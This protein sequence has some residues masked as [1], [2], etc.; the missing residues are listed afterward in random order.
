MCRTADPTISRNFR[1]F[2][3]PW[4]AGFCSFFLLLLLLVLFLYIV[5]DL[6]HCLF[7]RRIDE[8]LNVVL[9]H[10]I[11]PY[12][13]AGCLNCLLNSRLVRL[14]L[15]HWVV[16]LVPRQAFENVTLSVA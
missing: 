15:A 5:K 13:M 6:S 2:S 3:C 14:T 12:H 10:L 4:F 16:Q 11:H 7:F 9:V 1:K 8:V